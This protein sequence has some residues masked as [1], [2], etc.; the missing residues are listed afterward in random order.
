MAS[1]L[2]CEITDLRTGLPTCTWG[3]KTV[4]VHDDSLH[5]GGAV[6]REGT[7]YGGSHDLVATSAHAVRGR[8]SCGLE[9][10]GVGYD[11]GRIKERAEGRAPVAKY[12]AATTAML[13]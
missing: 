5:R 6:A 2:L 12:A 10:S 13:R 8:R 11:I 9:R 1:S 4:P 7:R 3:R